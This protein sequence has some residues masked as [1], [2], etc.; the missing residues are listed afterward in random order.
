MTVTE[1]KPNQTL[2][3]EHD[4]AKFLNVSVGTIRRWR[5]L[6]QPPD[7]LKIGSSVRYRPEAIQQLIERAEQRTGAWSSDAE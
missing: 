3:T 7:Y 5:L 2:L 6:R 1:S 4:V